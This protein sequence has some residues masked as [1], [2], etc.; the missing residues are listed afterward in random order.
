MAIVL[1]YDL[2]AKPLHWKINIALGVVWGIFYRLEEGFARASLVIFFATL[3]AFC[4]LLPVQNIK[5]GL[6][7]FKWGKA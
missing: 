5:S 7:F 1:T 2:L 3:I 4:R 6:P